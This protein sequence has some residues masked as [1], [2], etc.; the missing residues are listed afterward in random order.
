MN[1]SCIWSCA[2]Q[3]CSRIVFLQSI[4]IN[5][6][7]PN[8]FNNDS[9][10]KYLI[11]F[12]LSNR[13]EIVY[14][15]L[16][17]RNTT[18]GLWNWRKIWWDQILWINMIKY[19]DNCYE[20][21]LIGHGCGMVHVI[22]LRGVYPKFIHYL[23]IADCVSQLKWLQITIDETQCLIDNILFAAGVQYEIVANIYHHI[24][25]YLSSTDLM[26]SRANLLKE[27]NSLLG[28]HRCLWELYWRKVT[29]EQFRLRSAPSR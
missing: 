14:N 4:K 17:C 1:I 23:P 8:C 15:L 25:N 29:S 10:I 24:K 2:V 7:E 27:K 20:T 18:A 11:N 22:Y 9:T 13:I 16:L 26:C 12:S 5:L 28:V 19:V 3:V 21:G 6:I